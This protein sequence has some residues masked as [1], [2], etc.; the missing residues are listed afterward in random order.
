MEL[1]LDI[2]LELK[3]EVEQENLKLVNCAKETNLIENKHV[4]NIYEA[5][6]THFDNN[7][8]Y[9]WLWVNEFLNTLKPNAH[10]Y[11]IGCGNG[12]NMINN[13]ANNLIFTGIDNC[14]NFVKLCK[15]KNL[16]VIYSDMRDIPLK[17]NSADAIICIAVFHHLENK[18]NRVKSL[19]EM[20][21][22]I[23]L[24]GKIMLSVWSISQP[25]KTRR[26]FNNYGN[27]IVLYNKFG[28]I[29]ERFYY[30][31]KIDELHQ[32]FTLCGLTISD[33]KYVCGN[34]IF[35]LTKTL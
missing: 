32:L 7:R 27:N 11:D 22:L 6:A 25:Q 29:Y 16:N 1:E 34:E 24:G 8:S 28:E 17:S 15:S 30:I 20:K 13:N 23:K 19:L 26:S 5:I 10:V 4:K 12:R 35:I 21:R 33:Y 9:K 3:V 31:F 2:D 18:E 14:E